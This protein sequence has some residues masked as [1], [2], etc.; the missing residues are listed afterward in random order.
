M[1]WQVR[2]LCRGQLHPSEFDLTQYIKETGNRICVEVYKRSSA[3]WIEDQDFFRF[4]GMFRPVYLYAK[5]AV[6]L[7]DIW[8]KAGLSE[9]NTTGLLTPKLKLDERPKGSV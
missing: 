5:P 8:L 1:Q 3:A 9:D 4:S 6:H 2:G 7:A